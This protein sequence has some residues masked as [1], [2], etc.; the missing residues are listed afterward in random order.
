MHTMTRP[1]RSLGPS[2]RRHKCRYNSPMAENHKQF[3]GF[4]E[5]IELVGDD[6]TDLRKSRNANRDR[7]TKH[8]KETLKRTVPTF[9]EQ[10]SFEMGTV[11]RPITGDYDLDDGMYLNCIGD[12]PEKWPATSTIQGWVVDA[13][14]GA[15]SADPKK[16]K[17]CVRIPYKGGYHIDIP[18]YGTDS[19][20]TIRVFKKD[21]SPTEF[22]ESNPLALVAW[23]KER[24]ESHSDLRDLVRFF[25]AWRDKQGGRLSKV[26]SVAMTILV[27]EQIKSSDRYDLAVRDTARSCESFIRAG[28][29]IS[30]PVAPFDSLSSSWTQEDRTAIADAFKNLAD[31]GQDAIDADSIIEGAKI[32][33]KQFGDRFPVPEEDKSSGLT[34]GAQRTAG[35]AITGSG[36]FA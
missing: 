23:F 9:E 7:I 10:G 6:L 30:K 13:V 8:W 4:L 29:N 34:S 15:T 5:K 27:A 22:D 31:R 11:I 1:T 33:Q 17:R 16:M 21:Q 14:K 32:W 18:S 25:K 20:G 28:G 3:K 24:K 19:F 12:D 36:S 2:L 35:P 26:K